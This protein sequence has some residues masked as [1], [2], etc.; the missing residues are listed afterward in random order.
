MNTIQI[1][2]ST[3]MPNI[4]N[5]SFLTIV[6]YPNYY[7][8]TCHLIHLKN[9]KGIIYSDCRLFVHLFSLVTS[10]KKFIKFQMPNGNIS[11]ETCIPEKTCYLYPDTPYRT[12]LG[13]AQG[14]FLFKYKNLYWG[15]D[16]DGVKSM[17]LCQWKQLYLEKIRTASGKTLI[18]NIKCSIIY[19]K[20]ISKEII[21]KVKRWSRGKRTLA[22]AVVKYKKIHHKRQRSRAYRNN[23]ECRSLRF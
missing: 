16:R 21:F 6:P 11:R 15:L 12:S 3:N 19:N 7:N 1:K 5:Q 20:L 13:S 2:F 22:R 10:G 4:L 14:Q 18:Q 23:N 8:C 9:H 17:K